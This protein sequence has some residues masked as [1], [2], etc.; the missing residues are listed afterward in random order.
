MDSR[1]KLIL[2]VEGFR[3]KYP[4][5]TDF[6]NQIKLC[7]NGGQRNEV[8]DPD[9]KAN[10]IKTCLLIDLDPPTPIYDSAI[11]NLKELTKH[12][13][14]GPQSDIKSK[15]EALSNSVEVVRGSNMTAEQ[16][17]KQIAGKKF[18]LTQIF[19]EANKTDL[20]GV[21]E[22]MA[23]DVL[24]GNN[25]AIAIAI[26]SNLDTWYQ[27]LLDANQN[28]AKRVKPNANIQQVIPGPSQAIQ[29]MRSPAVNFLID[30]NLNPKKRASKMKDFLVEKAMEKRVSRSQASY[31]L[32]R[33]CQSVAM[34]LELA[35]THLANNNDCFKTY[36]RLAA[37]Q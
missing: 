5:E 8:T 19:Q 29:P 3:K 34:D 10:A 2:A 6:V 23:V 14:I 4:K 33:N 21:L 13:S 24:Q 15:I 35:K 31:L 30:S 22:E 27:L 36:N 7:L 9:S 20:E 11:E 28:P 18:E 25:A 26:A 37:D 16:K 32:C 12:L 17:V 1:Q